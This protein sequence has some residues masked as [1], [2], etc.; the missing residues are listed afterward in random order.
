MTQL[1]NPRHERFAHELA[2][3]KSARDAYELAGY[4]RNTGNCIRLKANES[5]RA[6]VAELQA[7]A[8]EL[9]GLTRA[10]VLGRL[11]ENVNRSMQYEAVT[12]REGA[13]TGEFAYQGAVANRGL[14]LLGKDIGMFVDRQELTGKDGQPLVPGVIRVP[15]VAKDGEAW[16]RQYGNNGG[17]P[18]RPA[19]NGNGSGN[20]S[21]R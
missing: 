10:W 21:K 15:V 2:L 6:R 5:I 14:E 12:D 4:S 3:G 20:E 11:M 16:E 18:A 8:A 17:L 9:V 1:T 7:E 19:V 13:P